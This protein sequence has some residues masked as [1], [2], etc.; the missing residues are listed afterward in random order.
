MEA[1]DRSRRSGLPIHAALRPNAEVSRYAG[2]RQ[3]SVTMSRP[4]GALEHTRDIERYE[5]APAGVTWATE[6]IDHAHWE[7]ALGSLDRIGADLDAIGASEVDLGEYC[8]ELRERVDVLRRRALIRL[9]NRQAP[10]PRLL[11][12][13]S[14]FFGKRHNS[15]RRRVTGNTRTLPQLLTTCGRPEQTLRAQPA[16][17]W[18]RGPSVH[19]ACNQPG[20]TGHRPPCRTPKA[21]A[22]TAC[23]SRFPKLT[24]RVRFPSP[25]RARSPGS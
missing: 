20:G 14:T 16:H 25:A 2:C 3:L 21:R 17:R 8:R 18:T 24:A 1:G 22:R 15:S 10:L 4:P 5:Q 6:P 13:N 12:H 23:S 19:S 9:D 11:R 7:T